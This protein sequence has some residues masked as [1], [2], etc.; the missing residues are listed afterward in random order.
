MDKIKE[1]LKANKNKNMV[2]CISSFAGIA[3]G[4]IGF[5]IE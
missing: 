5:P 1:K 4:V 2:F 3:R